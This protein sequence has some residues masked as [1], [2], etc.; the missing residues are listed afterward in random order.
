MQSDPQWSRTAC[1]TI[2]GI[3]ATL[4]AILGLLGQ[5]VLVVLM[6][7][8]LCKVAAMVFRHP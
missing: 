7:A 4:A 5:L 2:R 8:E 6:V 3:N 1:S